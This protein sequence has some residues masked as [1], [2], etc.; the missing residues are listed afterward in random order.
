MKKKIR[1][2]PNPDDYWM[3]IACMAAAGSQIEPR[4]GVAVVTPMLDLFSLGYQQLVRQEL[5]RSAVRYALSDRPPPGC[6][7]Y[8]T[9]S[10]DEDDLAELAAADVRRVVC[11]AEKIPNV[12][13][14]YLEIYHGSLGWMRDHVE[15]FS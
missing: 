7:A 13:F 5:G 1:D 8:L 6:T 11:R 3:G 9:F 14:P 4:H 15:A 2:V 10:P 12:S